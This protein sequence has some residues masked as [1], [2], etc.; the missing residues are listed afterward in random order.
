MSWSTRPTGRLSRPTRWR[1]PRS[2]P[3]KGKQRTMREPKCKG[4][5]ALRT[6]TSRRQSKEERE[7]GKE[8]EKERERNN[9]RPQ[10]VSVSLASPFQKTRVS[11]RLPD[12]RRSA[13]HRRLPGMRRQSPRR[14]ASLARCSGFA[15]SSLLPLARHSASPHTLPPQWHTLYCSVSGSAWL[16]PPFFSPASTDGWSRIPCTSWRAWKSAWRTSRRS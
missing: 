5:R 9:E 10:G 6:V 14:R 1:P 12:F 15:P 13:C 7:R 2:I 16:I 11:R 8:K 4:Q 3:T